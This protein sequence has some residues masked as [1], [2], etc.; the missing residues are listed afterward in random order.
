MYKGLI[1]LPSYNNLQ[2]I[3]NPYQV[4]NMYFDK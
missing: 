1:W 2:M 3:L 4:N